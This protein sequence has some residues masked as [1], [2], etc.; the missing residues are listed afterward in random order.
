MELVSQVR[1]SDITFQD[2]SKVPVYTHALGGTYDLFI[3][4]QIHTVSLPRRSTSSGP[5]IV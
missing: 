2:D 3:D 5:R 4:L 1:I